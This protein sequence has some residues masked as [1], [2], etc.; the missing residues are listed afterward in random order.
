MDRDGE[1]A[2]LLSSG[3][4]RGNMN[5]LDLRDFPHRF[6]CFEDSIICFWTFS[7]WPLLA[8]EM[9]FIREVS[10]LVIYWIGRVIFCCLAAC[11]LLC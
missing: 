8:H 1:V 7:F 3:S 10:R 4:K 11:F 2:L 9:K 5:R 6:L